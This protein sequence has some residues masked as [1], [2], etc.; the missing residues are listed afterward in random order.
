MKEDEKETGRAIFWMHY[1]YLREDRACPRIDPG[2]GS[3][4]EFG[5]SDS[6]TVVRFLCEA[7]KQRTFDVPAIWH[8]AT[9]L[10]SMEASV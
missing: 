1:E 5:G 10:L 4:F 9:D 2:A 8:L 6:F 3:R 7:W